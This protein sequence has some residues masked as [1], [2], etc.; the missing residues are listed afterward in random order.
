MHILKRTQCILCQHLLNAYVSGTGVGAYSPEQFIT[1]KVFL[2][3]YNV[4]IDLKFCINY[5]LLNLIL[6]VV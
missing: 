5:F 6:K 3:L 4:I 2:S 1:V